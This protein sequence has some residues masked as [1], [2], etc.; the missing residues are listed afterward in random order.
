[1][2]DELNSLLLKVASEAKES[3]D[4]VKSCLSLIRPEADWKREVDAVTDETSL[5]QLLQR[6]CFLSNLSLLK[7]IIEKLDLKESK[8]RIDQLAKERDAFYSKV[9]AEDFAA[10]G[11]EDHII[12]KGDHVEVSFI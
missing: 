4:E 12:I 8:S 9:L 1:M 3:L 2:R 11:I 6:Y 5:T 7:Y 10:A